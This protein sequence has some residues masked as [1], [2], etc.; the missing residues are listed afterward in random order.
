MSFDLGS[1]T[2]EIA[3]AIAF[4]FFLLSIIVTTVTEWIA[5]RFQFRAKVLRKGLEGMLG[6]KHVVEAIFCHPLVRTDLRPDRDRDPS[7][8]APRNFAAAFFDRVDLV[9]EGGQLS[10]ATVD[11][12]GKEQT[13][14]YEIDERLLAQLR[15][16]S[17]VSD[18][19]QVTSPDLEKWFEDSMDRVKGD[20]KR[21]SQIV[22]IGIS[23]V[24]VIGLNASTLRIAE[25]LSAEPAVRAAIVAKS[26]SASQGS[27]D[28]EQAGKEIESAVG[29][30]TSLKLP[31]FWAGENVPAWSLGAILTLLVGWAITIIAISLGAPFWFDALGKLSNLR[32]AGKKPKEEGGQPS[33]T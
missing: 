18:K 30:L 19:G 15:S 25:R 11:V 5:G 16:L 17:I 21:K 29:K 6:D 10:K 7:Y 13:Q 33:P 4:V 27:G 23:V 3:I 8:I 14:T 9:W 12:P 28:P 1:P 24:L 32:M 2:I 20:Y 31:L 22:T 26:E